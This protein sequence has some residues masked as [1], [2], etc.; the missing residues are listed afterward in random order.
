M[1]VHIMFLP[2]RDILPSR[3][4]RYFWAKLV[5][6]PSCRFSPPPPPPAQILR[7]LLC[8]G[9]PDVSNSA[10][11]MNLLFSLLDHMRRLLQIRRRHI[12]SSNSSSG[13]NTAISAAGDAA[14]NTPLV[15]KVEKLIVLHT[16]VVTEMQEQHPL[17]F[18]DMIT[19]TLQFVGQFSFSEEA[20]Q[21][22]FKRFAVQC[23]NLCRA[24]IR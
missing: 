12:D 1:L 4:F 5:I 6:H 24:I 20:V 8:H 9:F 21:F 18:V 14:A 16:K 2:S 13:G 10:D 23:L 22:L 15:E 11:A 3:P 19:P 7:K 17:A